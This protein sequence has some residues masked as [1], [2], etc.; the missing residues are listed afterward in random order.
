MSIEECNGGTGCGGHVLPLGRGIPVL[1]GV[2]PEEGLW[3]LG[4]TLCRKYA[5]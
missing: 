2:Q 4:L 5:N 3:S 1:V